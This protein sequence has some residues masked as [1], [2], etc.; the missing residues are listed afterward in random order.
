MLLFVQIV[1]INLS[2]LS[3][4]MDRDKCFS[5]NNAS[6]PPDIN[7]QSSIR[8]ANLGEAD[9]ADHASI[10]SAFYR[11]CFDYYWGGRRID[12]SGN[13]FHVFAIGFSRTTLLECTVERFSGVQPRFEHP[14][15]DIMEARA[16]VLI[17]HPTQEERKT[18]PRRKRDGKE[19]TTALHLSYVR[20]NVKRRRYTDAGHSSKWFRELETRVCPSTG[21]PLRRT[22]ALPAF[23]RSI[24]R[25]EF[26]KGVTGLRNTRKINVQH[27][28]SETARGSYYWTQT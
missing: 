5:H 23:P 9:D 20:P 17:K 28:V 12:F 13:A 10:K 26:L 15:R 25:S 14:P 18:S 6:F 22:H 3:V 2:V 16:G 21:S 24:G 19:S 1:H 7:S 8:L 11:G 27:R 4:R